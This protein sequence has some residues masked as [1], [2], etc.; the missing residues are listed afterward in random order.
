MT[1]S[2]DKIIVSAVFRRPVRDH[3][4]NTAQPIP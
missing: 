2:D 1:V 3:R 4:R